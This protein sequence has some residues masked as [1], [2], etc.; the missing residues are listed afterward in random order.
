MSMQ[1]E[2]RPR[3]L[4]LAFLAGA[5]GCMTYSN[6][7]SRSLTPE[8][9]I[10]VEFSAPISLRLACDAADTA[11][12]ASSCDGGP[13]LVTGIMALSGR[14]KRVAEDSVLVRLAELRDSSGQTLRYEPPREAWLAHGV[15]V[16]ETRHTSTG[17][18]VLLV[19]FAAATV[20][21]VI[22]AASMSDPTPKPGGGG[23][24]G[25]Y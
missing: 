21:V 11:G 23:G 20:A 4:A 9:D 17:R 8:R 3:L 2:R 22:A 1:R 10:K 13:A 6:T 7:A 25:W 18:T 16:F 14:V 15:G 5:A 24:S 19:V 12:R